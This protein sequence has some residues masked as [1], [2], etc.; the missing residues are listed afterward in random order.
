M[1]Y[2]KKISNKPLISVIIDTFNRPNELKNTI[3]HILDQTY[4]NIEIVLVD[5]AANKITKKYIENLRKNNKFKF[6]TYEKNQFSF[7]DPQRMIKICCNEALKICSGELVFYLSDDDWIEKSFF[8]KIIKLFIL[9]EKCTSAIGRVKSYYNENKIISQPLKKQPVF[10]KGKELCLDKAMSINKFDQSNPG[11]SYVFKT[12]VLKFYGGFFAPLETHQ[13]FGVVAFGESAFDKDAIM[14]WRRHE[15]Q[16]N[17][18]LNKRCYFEGNYILDLLNQVENNII[19]NWKKIYS[20]EESQIVENYFNQ[21]VLYS[22]Y[23]TFFCLIFKAKLFSAIS[24]YFEKNYIIRKKRLSL[25]I[26]NKSL[27]E[28]FLRS[29]INHKYMAIIFYI[30][31]LILKKK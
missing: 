8:S 25:Q 1:F 15:N 24:F 2:G 3:D 14:Y 12:D 17:K 29:Y 28:A 26:I 6:L 18:M 4:Q 13:L 5:N 23:K 11:H 19:D 21:I 7:E 22:F 16:L 9:N 20:L 10:L 30:K 31:M 27:K